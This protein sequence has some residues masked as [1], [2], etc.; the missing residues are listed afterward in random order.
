MPVQSE[1]SKMSAGSSRS[2]GK[3][4]AKNGSNK[5]AGRGT[6]RKRK[7][8]ESK[9]PVD[10]RDQHNDMERQRRVGLRVAY[11]HLKDQLPYEIRSKK[12]SKVS[13]LIES[14]KYA[15]NLTATEANLQE[16]IQVLKNARR[17]MQYEKNELIRYFKAQQARQM[18]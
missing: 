8:G 14:T 12:I 17:Q 6:K 2:K 18:Q 10:K 16:E 5:R 1:Q 13:I 7:H 15:N 4:I 3:R 9:T 11:D